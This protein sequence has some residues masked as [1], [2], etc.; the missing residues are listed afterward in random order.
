MD[1]Q[2]EGPLSSTNR[3]SSYKDKTI[4]D[5]Y[6]TPVCEII[7]FLK[8][9]V[10]LEPDILSGA[11]L[12]PSAGGDPRH[13]MSYPEALKKMGVPVENILTMDVREDSPA[14]VKGD[15]LKMK[16]PDKFNLAIT[17][18]PFVHAQKFI[19]KALKDVSENGFVIMLLRLNF[20]GS[21]R[22]K[23]L[24]DNHMPKYVFVHHER[25]SFTDDGRTDSVEYMHAVWQVGNK[26]K[27]SKLFVI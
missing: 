20:F 7:K 14:D 23:V 12:D 11:I 16:F 13:P 5:Y 3:G 4:T 2:E 17:N 22:R 24:W 15:Y 1:A 9:L 26:T 8:P 27:Y 6:V 19:D 25:M 18:P 10:E 21:R